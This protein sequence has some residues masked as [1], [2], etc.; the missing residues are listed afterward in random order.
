MEDGDIKM[1]IFICHSK[2]DKEQVRALYRKLKRSRFDPWL[3]EEKLIP[4]QDWDQEIRK[5]INESQAVIVCLSKVSLNKEGYVQKEIRLA[6]DI[7]DEKPPETIF[8]IPLR[9]E[10][11]DIPIRLRKWQWVDLFE[12]SGYKQL[13]MALDS[14]AE[15]LGLSRVNHRKDSRAV[16]ASGE[17]TIEILINEILEGKHL[18]VAC[19][20]SPEENPI[21]GTPLTPSRFI[22]K[23]ITKARN[24]GVVVLDYDGQLVDYPHVYVLSYNFVEIASRMEEF[25]E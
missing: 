8:L 10:D 20:W 17:G 18:S 25:S 14:R 16:M 24:A 19:C 11:C 12:K 2:E 21:T 9:L 3:D 6:L 7:A 23:L 22:E 13:R 1:K 4:G 15:Q 5:A